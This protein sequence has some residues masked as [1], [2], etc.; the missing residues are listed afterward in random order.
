MHLASLISTGFSIVTTLSRTRIIAQHLV[1]NYG[2][3]RFC[4]NI[5]TTD[6][7]VLKLEIFYCFLNFAL[8]TRRLLISGP[9]TVIGNIQPSSNSNCLVR[10]ILVGK[11]WQ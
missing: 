6:L 8:Y 9:T 11:A 5:R 10:L 3:T 1:K 4:R 2:M 7:A